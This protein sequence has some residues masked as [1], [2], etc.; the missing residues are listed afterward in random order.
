MLDYFKLSFSSLL[1]CDANTEQPLKY[2]HLN[3]S[4]IKNTKKTKVQLIVITSS[5]QQQQQQQQPQL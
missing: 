1:M 2:L 3:S 4:I 5:S